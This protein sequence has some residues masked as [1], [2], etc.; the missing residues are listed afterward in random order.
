[1]VERK[2]HADIKQLME[3]SRVYVEGLRLKLNKDQGLSCQSLDIIRDELEYSKEVSLK[4]KDFL[5]RI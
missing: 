5:K 1:M 3:N 2:L 4:M